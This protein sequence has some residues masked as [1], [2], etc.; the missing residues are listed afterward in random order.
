MLPEVVQLTVPKVPEAAEKV[1]VPVGATAVPLLVSETV[2]VQVIGEPS[3]AEDEV[4]VSVTEVVRS[5]TATVAVVEL[6]A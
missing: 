5:D 3:V 6:V 1:T 4:Q 2:A